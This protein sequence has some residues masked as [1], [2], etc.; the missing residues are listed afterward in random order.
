MNAIAAQKRVDFGFQPWPHQAVAHDLRAQVRFL[1]LVWH[2][3]A[4]KT[5]FAVLELLLAA[6]EC[7]AEEAA[8]FAYV[9]PYLKQAKAVAWDYLKRYARRLPGTTVNE[10]ELSVKL[11][12]GAQVRLHGGDN[13]DSLRGTYLNGVVIDELADIRP[14]VWGEIIRP[15]LADRQGWGLF[16]GTP[17]GINLF[18]ELYERAVSGEDPDWRG[19]RLQA[20]D[21]QVLDARE[22]EAARREMSP[23]QFAQEFEVDFGAASTNSLIKLELVVRAQKRVVT[24]QEYLSQAKVMGVDVARFGDDR[25]CIAFRQ[26]TVAFPSVTLWHQDT[27]EVAARVADAYQ[28]WDADACFIDVGGVGAGVYDRC[29]ALN[30]NVIPVDFGAKALASER[31]EDRRSEIWW[32][33]AQWMERAC[34]PSKADALKVD[35]TAPR[36]TFANKRGRW[37]LESKDEMKKRGLKSPDEGD[38][39]AVTFANPVVPRPRDALGGLAPSGGKALTKY[40]PFERR[41]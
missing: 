24:P 20:Q 3:R 30:L 40:D 39:L 28:R 27:M 41:S 17:K 37:Q 8:R 35:L 10:S 9:A 16:I 36:Y 25:T 18:S 38:A 22:I 14:E 12:N 21:T 5:V 13:P 15:A 32:T 29:L 26:G 23:A 6:I 7:S 1:V 31:F 2:R 34:L 33:M 11:P 19:Q 4:G